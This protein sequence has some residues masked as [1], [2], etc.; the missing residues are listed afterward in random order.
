MRANRWLGQTEEAANCFDPFLLL[1]GDGSPSEY[2]K[3]V[4]LGGGGSPS[5]YRNKGGCSTYKLATLDLGLGEAPEV[6]SLFHVKGFTVLFP[7]RTCFCLWTHK[8][9]HA[10][11]ENWANRLSAFEGAIR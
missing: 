9:I 1:G 11:R 8:D 6:H 3:I 10:F 2:R 4:V 7:S 5:E